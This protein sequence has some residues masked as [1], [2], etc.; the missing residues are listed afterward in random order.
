MKLTSAE[1]QL[2]SKLEY[3]ESMYIIDNANYN[4]MTSLRIFGIVP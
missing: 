1:S 3:I 2:S 4:K